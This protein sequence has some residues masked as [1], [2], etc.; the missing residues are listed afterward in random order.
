MGTIHGSVYVSRHTCILPLYHKSGLLG[1][2][3]ALTVSDLF[4]LFLSN[5]TAFFEQENFSF[6]LK[7]VLDPCD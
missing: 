3:A 2:Y 4:S 1:L 5:S 7:Q 6:F